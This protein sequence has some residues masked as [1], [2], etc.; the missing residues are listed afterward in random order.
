MRAAGDRDL[1]HLPATRKLWYNPEK[2]THEGRCPMPSIAATKKVS[3]L[4]VGELRELIQDTVGS[5]IDPDY[6]ME[7]R[8]EVEQELR[9]SLSREGEGKLYSTAEVKALLGL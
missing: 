7:L 1:A 3:E 9:E 8:P 2:K 4:T 6:G 5:M